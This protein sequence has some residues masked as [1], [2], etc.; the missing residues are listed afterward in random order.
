MEVNKLYYI[1]YYTVSRLTQE[2][3]SLASKEYLPQ[4]LYFRKR[5]FWKI[6]IKSKRIDILKS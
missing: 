4:A 2:L 5:K 3:T 6:K 1:L